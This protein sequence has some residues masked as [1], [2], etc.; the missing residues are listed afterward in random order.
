M[1]DSTLRPLSQV[2]RYRKQAQRAIRQNTAMF[3]FE[4]TFTDEQGGTWVVNYNLRDPQ[5]INREAIAAAEAAA[6]EFEVP[7][8]DLRVLTIDPAQALPAVGASI[9]HHNADGGFEGLAVLLD[10]GQPG[11]YSGLTRGT[12]VLRR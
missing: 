9:R 5:Q 2:D 6:R 4:G 3:P 1:A 10:W 7:Y 11:T 12:C 8:R